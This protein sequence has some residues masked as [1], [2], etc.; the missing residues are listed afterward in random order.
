M[1]EAPE[2]SPGVA[3]RMPLPLPFSP[4]SRVAVAA[5]SSAV[6]D[7]RDAE[8]G[9]GALR[10]RGLTVETGRSLAPRVGYLSGT[11]ADR[12]H[13]MNTLFA[14]DDLDAILCVRG[15]FGALRILDLLDWDALRAHPKLIIGYSDITALHLAAWSQAEVPGLSAAMAAPDW[16]EIDPASEQ[17]LW[18]V[19][20]GAHPWTV[21]GPGGEP[22]APMNAGTAEG[23][24]IGGNL[25]LIASLVGT[26]YMPDL[27]GAILFL[28][29]IG[30]LPYRI[31]GYLAHLRLAGIL[32]RLGGLVYGAFTEGDPGDRPT[33]SLDEVLEHY[34][35]FVGGPVARGLVYGHFP[36]KTPMPVGV[37]ARLTVGARADL[38]TL[39]PL[40]AIPT[41][42]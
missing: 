38:A 27:T 1:R 22:L 39:S 7:R 16:P 4:H 36:R 18:D 2:A 32:E 14:R 9:L 29:D 6:A 40:T 35:Q 23:T 33:L 17:Q 8:A 5:P 31:D 41:R 26:P 15:G 42:D 20:S 28:E 3:S 34:A 21:V 30:E 25:Y 10:A 12:A 19:A 37:Q 24:L 11:D 13:E